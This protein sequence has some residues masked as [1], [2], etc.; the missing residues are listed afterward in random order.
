MA[1][2]WIGLAAYFEM[3]S[4]LKWRIVDLPPCSCP[5]RVSFSTIWQAYDH[6]PYCPV[7]FLKQVI[8]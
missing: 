1:K 6:A 7:Q 3:Y 5:C 8:A 2:R 4:A